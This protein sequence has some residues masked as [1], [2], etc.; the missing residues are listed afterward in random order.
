MFYVVIPGVVLSTPSWFQS[1]NHVMPFIMYTLLP[2]LWCIIG[3]KC[4]LKPLPL[5]FEHIKILR[6][7]VNAP[8]PFLA[9]VPVTK[10]KEGFQIISND[11]AL[12]QNQLNFFQFNKI[13]DLSNQLVHVGG[14]ANFHFSSINY[15]GS[16][17][18]KLKQ[19]KKK[20]TVGHSLNN[21]LSN[22][23]R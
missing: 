15:L 22:Y 1:A 7:G 16:R 9:P 6:G 14:A 23:I 21:V 19:K 17:V 11:L 4:W 2:A 10:N 18:V 5:C 12:C 3:H 20:S 13:K 8:P